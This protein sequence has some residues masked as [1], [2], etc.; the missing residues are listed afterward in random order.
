M[1]RA[2]LIYTFVHVKQKERNRKESRDG[3][4]ASIVYYYYNALRLWVYIICMIILNS[5]YFS[6]FFQKS[7]INLF[8]HYL[9]L[10]T[11]K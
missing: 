6:Y 3:K 1:L 2:C 5:W 9:L 8:L 7:Y 10:G 4:K 11:I